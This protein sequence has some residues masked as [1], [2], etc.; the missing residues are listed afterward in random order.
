[1]VSLRTTKLIE[2]NSNKAKRVYRGVHKHS[3]NLEKVFK[4]LDQYTA[5]GFEKLPYTQRKY[6]AY[7][8]LPAIREALG[9]NIDH[10]TV[11]RLIFDNPNGVNSQTK[12]GVSSAK[13]EAWAKTECYQKIKGFSECWDVKKNDFTKKGKKYEADLKRVFEITKTDPLD[14]DLKEWLQFWGNPPKSIGTAHPKFIDGMTGR[15]RFSAAISFRFAMSKSHNPYVRE[16]L[17]SKDGNYTTD[18]LKR[19]KGLHKEEFQN[20]QQ[21]KVLP[22]FFSNTEILM[23]DYMGILFGGRFDALKELTPASV[24]PEFNTIEFYEGKVDRDVAKPIYEPEL[25]F[26]QRF[27]TD[28]RFARN[29]KLFPNSISHYNTQ[30]TAAGYA[31]GKKYP[32]LELRND[33]NEVWRLTTHRGFKHTC[34]SQ[35]SLHGVRRDVISDYIG[36]D[37]ATLKEF[38]QGGGNINIH[39]EIGGLKVQQT[40]PTWRAFVVSITKVFEA[41]YNQLIAQERAQGTA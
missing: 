6:N 34:V 7:G 5:K 11:K 28:K 19:P 40:E 4:V 39:R 31:M 15:V 41:R 3:H 38:Y 32:E 37:E 25:G 21:I 20:E 18:K 14:L 35:M 10:K 17:N 36:T 12:R 16:A 23:L 24:K 26:I 9:S 27:I 13:V 33:K 29:Q 30:L 22:E 8:M 2:L 1:M